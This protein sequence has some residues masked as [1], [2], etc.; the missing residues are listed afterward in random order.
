MERLPTLR[1]TSATRR[2]SSRP[3]VVETPRGTRILKLCGAA[4][5]TGAL[6]AEIIVAEL[7]EALGLLV[8]PRVLVDLPAEIETADWDDELADLLAASVGVNLGFDYLADAKDFTA[9]DVERVPP[10][11]RA[12]IM[13][14]DRLVMNH[15]RSARNPNI[16]WWA[17]Q[18]WLIDHGASLSFQYAWDRVTEDAPRQ[19]R[20]AREA[21][22]FE[23]IVTSGELHAADAALAPQVTRELLADAVALVPEE[24]LL[25]LQGVGAG[26]RADEPSRLARQ[27][28]A[29]V[30][31]LWKR[32]RAPRPFLDP[33]ELPVT[34]T[35]R[36]PHWL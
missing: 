36:R 20:L 18:P 33:R 11:T 8:P 15:D 4:Q 30:A 22:L 25:P 19:P 34:P 17:G 27:R 13:W 21:H 2:G 32:L 14:L 16:L 9:A 24:F 3:I 10:A 6:V 7:A 12:T 31:F 23:H 35:A 29:Y 1:I 5:G 28:A 26:E